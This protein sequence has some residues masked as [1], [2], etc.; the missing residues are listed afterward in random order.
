[1]RSIGRRRRSRAQDFEPDRFL[2]GVADVYETHEA[3]LYEIDLDGWSAGA[4]IAPRLMHE[5]PKPWVGLN[6]ACL[7]APNMLIAAGMAELIWRVDLRDNSQAS[8]RVW[9]QH[10]S[11]K[12]A[13]GE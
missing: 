6:G 11:R 2:L 9:L 12:T 3:R 8:A 10:D 4:A 5:F 7:V 1:M 13:R